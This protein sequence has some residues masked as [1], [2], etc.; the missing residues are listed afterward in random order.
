VAHKGG[1]NLSTLH[2]LKIADCQESGWENNQVKLQRFQLN[3]RLKFYLQNKL[4]AQN[5]KCLEK[6][7]KYYSYDRERTYSSS[8]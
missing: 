8:L 3:F 6:C 7:Q 1:W 5:L 4:S 2:S